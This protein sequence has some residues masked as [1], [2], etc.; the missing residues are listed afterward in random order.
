MCH[1]LDSD[2]SLPQV[3]RQALEQ[4]CFSNLITDITIR[5]FQELSIIELLRVSQTCRRFKILAFDDHV[6]LAKGRRFGL[7]H[8]RKL[9]PT[10]VFDRLR[11]IL[12]RFG[13][14]AK[15]SLGITNVPK[16]VAKE[17]NLFEILKFIKVRDTHLTWQTLQYGR[18]HFR[19]KKEIP[20]QWIHSFT[21]REKIDLKG[22]YLCTLPQELSFLTR[23]TQIQLSYN[24]L[25]SIKEIFMLTC[26]KTL[27]VSHN[28]LSDLPQEMG[29]LEKLEELKICSNHELQWDPVIYSLTSLRDLNLRDCKV[30]VIS[31]DIYKLTRLVFLYLGKNSI[32]EIPEEIGELKQLK[33][34]ELPRNQLQNLPN[35]LWELTQLNRL[36][37]DFNNLTYLSH[38]I[39]CLSNLYQLGLFDNNVVF[40]PHLLPS[41]RWLHVS[42]SP[43]VPLANVMIELRPSGEY[44]W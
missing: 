37:L 10:R 1:S 31:K 14:L 5:I 35:R 32:R 13:A 8:F 29:A 9:E 21:Q 23:L 27:D 2:I 4:G 18:C 33:V 44:N 28:L 11:E 6:W 40:E 12:F 7:T 38:Q 41:L 34:L 16:E 17:E 24:Y 43:D 26:L 20:P 30:D 3:K 25:F 36:N 42:R 19:K 39:T 15:P 22:L